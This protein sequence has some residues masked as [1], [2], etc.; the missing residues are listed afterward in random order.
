MKDWLIPILDNIYKG[1]AC[2]R[3]KV[4]IYN[5]F[6]SYRYV[7]DLDRGQCHSCSGECQFKETI[8]GNGEHS[9]EWYEL[10]LDKLNFKLL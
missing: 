7:K 9:K 10:G 1:H 6:P 3:M 8:L 4:A 5:G 2:E